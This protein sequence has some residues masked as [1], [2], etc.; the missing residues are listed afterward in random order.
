[1]VLRY[2]APLLLCELEKRY[3]RFLGDVRLP[4]ASKAAAPT[5]AAAVGADEPPVVVHVPNTGPMTGLLDALPAPALLSKAPPGAK[6]KYPLGL[7]W[8]WQGGGGGDGGTW[9]GVHSAKANAMARALLEAHLLDEEL[10]AYES[11]HPGGC[12]LLGLGWGVW[13]GGP[14]GLAG[15]VAWLGVGCMDGWP[16]RAGGRGCLAWGGMYGWVAQ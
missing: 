15:A 9:V 16:N 11:V 8:V 10:P 13:M 7:E 12:R 6:R 1:V 4:A 2:P 14:I 5:A 3:K